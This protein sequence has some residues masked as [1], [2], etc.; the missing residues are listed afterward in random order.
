MILFRVFFGFCVFVASAFANP[1]LESRLKELPFHGSYLPQAQRF[2]LRGS[3]PDF[4]GLYVGK[5][6]WEEGKEHLKMFLTEHQISYR[7]LTA[8]QIRNGDLVSSQVRVLIVPGGESWQYLSELGEEGAANIKAF[9]NAGGGYLGICAG[10]FYATSHREGGYATGKY[11]IGLLEGTAYDGTALGTAP[12]IEGMMDFQMEPHPLVLG[13]EE[14]FRIVMFGGPSF[15]FTESEAQKK[16][17]RVMARFRGFLEP[18]MITFHYGSGP[19]FLTG[20]HFEIEEDRTE[21]GNDFIDPDSEW[22]IL[23]RVMNYLSKNK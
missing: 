3:E 13:L 7:S 14:Q 1:S 11:G 12:F 17:I 2:G 21:W 15:R 10:A 5:G 8:Q 23:E 6:T 9:V 19:V 20:P 4:V 22:P 16:G 18:A